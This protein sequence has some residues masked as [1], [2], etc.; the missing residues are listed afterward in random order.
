[1]Y[2][3]LE[4]MEF[5]LDALGNDE[6]LHKIYYS[7]S[8]RFKN[9][10]LKEEYYAST[11]DLYLDAG[12]E[13]KTQAQ[14]KGYMRNYSCPRAKPLLADDHPNRHFLRV[15]SPVT[16]NVLT[17]NE[18]GSIVEVERLLP[19]HLYSVSEAGGSKVLLDSPSGLMLSVEAE[20][21]EKVSYYRIHAEGIDQ[22]TLV[23]PKSGLFIDDGSS[24]QFDNIYVFGLDKPFAVSIHFF[25]DLVM[26]YKYYEAA[27]AFYTSVHAS[28]LVSDVK[29]VDV[30]WWT[31]L[32]KVVI[33]VVTAVITYISGGTLTA[34]MMSILKTAVVMFMVN[35]ATMIVMGFFGEDAWL[36]TLLVVAAA[37]LSGNY[38]NLIGAFQNGAASL[39]GILTEFSSLMNTLY[40]GYN[41]YQIQDAAKEYEAVMDMIKQ[42]ENV[43]AVVLFGIESKMD[44]GILFQDE[45]QPVGNSQ[46]SIM[47][48]S[49]YLASF[50]QFTEIGVN[51]LD[52]D[53]TFDNVLE[54]KQIL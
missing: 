53:R 45:K 8:S 40:S 32:L 5:N 9:G 2:K 34:V 12:Y 41:Q 39:S 23:G 3:K 26:E 11:G 49:T 20:M 38:D 44:I 27:N 4:F 17:Q 43:W 16:V 25:P 21:L 31:I 30:P 46:L 19:G 14:V 6:E 29:Y 10:E 1:M 51:L 15:N 52:V 35:L 42:E 13:A 47:D 48:P 28:I 36:A 37:Y 7:D 22:I 33:L 18:E 24:D 54:A 50:E